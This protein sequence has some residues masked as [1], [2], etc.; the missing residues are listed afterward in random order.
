MNNGSFENGITGWTVISES[1]S[2]GNFYITT[3][4]TSPISGFQIDLATQGNQY[5][6][7]DQ[8]GQGSIVLYQDITLSPG[9]TYSLSFDYF[10]QSYAPLNVTSDMSWTGDLIEPHRT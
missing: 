3:G 10:A 6:V 9:F 2:D 1:G 8:N 5:I 4:G 7:S